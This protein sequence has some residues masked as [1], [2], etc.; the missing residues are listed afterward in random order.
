MEADVR[1]MLPGIH[2]Y[3][4]VEDTYIIIVIVKAGEV[5]GVHKA[6]VE[7]MREEAKRTTGQYLNILDQKR[8]NATYRDKDYWIPK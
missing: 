6:W 2:Y 1:Y 4:I 7:S 3:V 8:P 5:G